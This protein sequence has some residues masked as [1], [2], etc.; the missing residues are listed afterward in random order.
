MFFNADQIPG[1]Y[2]IGQNLTPVP[3]II[4]DRL[5]WLSFQIDLP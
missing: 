5:I 1:K 3:A 4:F 2:P